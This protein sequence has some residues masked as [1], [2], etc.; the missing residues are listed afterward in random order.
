DA[1]FASVVELHSGGLVLGPDPFLNSRRDQLIAMAAHYAV[2]T[3]YDFRENTA[4]GGLISYGPSLAAGNRQA[5][6]YAGRILKGEKPAELPVQQPTTF[7]LVANLKPA[8]AL[9][10]TAP[11]STLAR[12][13]EL[14]DR[15]APTR[16]SPRAT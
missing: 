3:I 2:P 13:D 14:S 9:G 8:K 11:P 10:R 1:A 4:A 6:R 15:T 7:E 16:C 5:G 12:A